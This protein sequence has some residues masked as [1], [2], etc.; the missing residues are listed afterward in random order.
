MCVFPFANYQVEAL[1]W[2]YNIVLVLVV[3][4]GIVDTVLLGPTTFNVAK[5]RVCSSFVCIDHA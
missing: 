3:L 4:Y 1:V 5:E 2:G